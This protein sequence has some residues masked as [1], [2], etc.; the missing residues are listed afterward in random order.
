MTTL[1]VKNIHTLATFDDHQREI[2]HGA[3]YI[4]DNIIEQV[5]ITADL[6]NTADEVLDLRD[7][8]VVL[9]GLVNTHHHFFQTLTRTYPAAQ[10]KELFHWLQNLYLAWSNLTSKLFYTSVQMAA[11]ELIL[12]GCTTASDHHYL[13]PNDCTLDD[14]IRAVQAIGLRFH[15]SR[16]SMTIGESQGGLPPDHLIESED[17]VIQ[18][19][20]RLIEQYHNS[21]RY[22]MLRMTLAPCSPFT[23]SQDLMRESAAMARS[24]DGVRLHTHLAENTSDVKYSLEMFGQIPGDYAESLGWLGEDVWHAHCVKLTDHSITK[25]GQTGTGVA[26]CPCSNMRLAS[27]IAPIRKMLN[28]HVPIGLGVDGSASNDSGNLLHEARMALLAARVR[29]EDPTAL[30]ARDALAIATRGGARVLGRDDVGM[31]ATGMAADFIA[32]N[33]D[34][35]TLAGALHDPIAALLFCHIDQVDYSFINGQ[36]VVNQGMLTTIDLPN[37]VETHNRAAQKLIAGE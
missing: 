25:F 30:T 17:F 23:V 3:L 5:G 11:A 1:L 35:P 21:D 28:H 36:C 8:H 6:P 19:S 18:D 2:R 34:R 9:P 15:A 32:I 12:S 22:A 29:D 31:L 13:Y 27:G 37:L 4:R 26:H 24:Y 16:G 20:Q 7:R 10:N 33:L 14:E